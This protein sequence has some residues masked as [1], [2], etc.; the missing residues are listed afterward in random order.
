MDGEA[1]HKEMNSRQKANQSVGKKRKV[2]RTDVEPKKPKVSKTTKVAKKAFTLEDDGKPCDEVQIMPEVD[3][4]PTVSNRKNQVVLTSDELSY[5]NKLVDKYAAEN[6]IGTSSSVGTQTEQH[7]HTCNA[8][9]QTDSNTVIS[10]NHDDD[11]RRLAVIEDKLDIVL[12]KL[13]SIQGP[14]ATSSPLSDFIPSPPPMHPQYPPSMHPHYPPS[15]RPQYPPPPPHYP[16]PQSRYPPPPQSQY[17]PPAPL[18]FNSDHNMSNDIHLDEDYVVP[19][20]L[21]ERELA[22]ATSFTNYAKRLVFAVFAPDERRNR[23]VSGN[24]TRGLAKYPL[25]P[26]KM[27]A[28]REALFTYHPQY[29]PADKRETEWKR[30]VVEIDKALRKY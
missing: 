6:N 20:E 13:E 19:K 26:I 4:T 18:Q 12:S 23:T 27:S 14:S 16:P 21:A 1:G 24:S 30:C 28:V 8:E 10:L 7:T 22:L 11:R 3:S 25:C 17:P 2:K 5:V 15:M 9:T 29:V